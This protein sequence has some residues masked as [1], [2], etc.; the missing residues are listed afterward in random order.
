MTMPRRKRSGSFLNPN[1][2][3]GT[4]LFFKATISILF[5]LFVLWFTKD[6]FTT[7]FSGPTKTHTSSS[8]V[9]LSPDPPE[10]TFYDDP[11]VSFSIENPITNW[12]EKR[13]QWL[14]LHPSLAAGARDRVLMVT[15]SQPLPC[16]N[17]VGDHLLLRSFKNK[18]DY[19]RLQGCDVF[20]SNV[21]LHPK[22][23]SYWAKLPSIRSAMMAHPEVEWIWWMDAD[24]VVTDMEFKLPLENYKDHN[25]IVHG[26]ENM[27]YDESEN[28]SWTGLNTGSY[29]VRNCQWSMDLLQE[30]SKMGPMT[31]EYEKW[32]K[33]LMRMFKDKPF[34]LPDDQ[35]SLI[36][37]LYKERRKWGKKTY[38]EGGYDLESY[39]IAVMGRFEEIIF[40]YND[41][42]EDVVA[43]R[44]RHAEKLSKWY[45][46]LREPYLRKRGWV[47]L[48]K[49][50]RPFVTHFTGCQPCSGNHNPSYKGDTCWKQ[51]EKALNFGDDQVLRKYGFVRNNLSTSSV[52]EVPFDY[53]WSDLLR[54][55]ILK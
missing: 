9:V 11:H 22:M 40:G 12:D 36:Y 5:F 26:W 55:S 15:G 4:L 31:S 33:I 47:P 34:P 13:S 16:K 46:E 19:C 18:V 42:E 49:G 52:H 28:K 7:L 43:L 54:I 37:M 8:N 3:G 50:K 38:L 32:G 48:S 20:Y 27:V 1:L 25:L 29:L 21:Y 35:S 17:P 45:G 51:M 39:W 10:K 24:A 14:R 30:W 23:D 44:R 2:N 6:K 53:P 41:L